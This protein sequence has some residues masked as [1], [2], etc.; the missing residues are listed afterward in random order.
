VGRVSV[1]RTAKYRRWAI[2][3]AGIA[4]L[5]ALPGAVAALP[6][7]AANVSASVLE[8]R[9]L[10]SADHPY[11]G[12]AENVGGLDLPQLPQLGTVSSL[13]S[14]STM[15][16]TWFAGPSQWRTDV[17]TDT[18]E[19]DMYQ[20]AQ[21]TTSWDFETGQVTEVVGDP[22]IRLPQANDFV[23]P[24]LGLRLLH[25]AAATDPVTSLPSRRIAGI[26][27]DGIEITPKAT[28][29]TIGR[30]DI[31]AD[32]ATGVPL[33]V[34]VYARGA[35]MPVV[36]TR[37]LDVELTAPATSTV[38]F[39][40]AAGLGISSVTSSDILSLL[41]NRAIFPL[42]SSLDGQAQSAV[43]QELGG[44][45]AG[46][47]SGFATF[48]VLALGDRVGDSAFSAA[49]SASAPVKF[50]DGTGELIQTPLLTVL[51]ARSDEFDRVYLLAGFIT[52]DPLVQAGNQL[53]SAVDVLP[54]CFQSHSC[55]FIYFPPPAS[56]ATPAPAQGSSR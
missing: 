38:T 40:P 52:P 31:W 23:P 4:V 2:V 9:I 5:C 45:A 15:I 13:L 39:Q 46:Y 44:G 33:E 19:Q 14:G 24:Q 10:A 53:M 21:A 16:R 56:Q 30:V 28:D 55:G 20:T 11:Q 17:V 1:V 32:P 12:Y 18:G 3:G 43:L 6:V 25:T 54:R 50:T 35:T 48:A 37:F 7:D 29:T 41:D 27:A 22:Q 8:A 36:S 26:A 47:G 49:A 51:L 42:P 34:S